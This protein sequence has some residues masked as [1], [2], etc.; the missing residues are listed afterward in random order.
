M[1]D[2]SSTR[3]GSSGRRPTSSSLVERLRRRPFS[4]TPSATLSEKKT[5]FQPTSDS[6]VERVRLAAQRA[7]LQI[8]PPVV[9][10]EEI[11]KRFGETTPASVAAPREFNKG[12]IA[13]SRSPELERIKALPRRAASVTES[14]IADLHEELCLPGGTRRLR[15]IQALALAEAR[16]TGGLFAPIGVGAGKSDIALLLPT[17]MQSKKAVLF[18]PANLRKKVFEQ[19]YPT[20]VDQY[21]VPRLMSSKIEPLGA[22]TLLW[23][24]SYNELSSPTKFD[25]LEK[26]E[27]DLVICD[28]AHAL[29]Y[30]SATRTKRFL[31]YFKTHRSTRLCVL[32][33][34]MTSKSI[35]DYAHL[36]WLSL[37]ENVPLPTKW[38]ALEEWAAALDSSFQPAPPGALLELCNEGESAREGFRRRVIETPGVV[39]TTDNTIGTSLVFFERSLKAPDNVVAA[40][41][42]MRETWT[43]PDQGEAFDDILTLHRFARQ[44]AAGF[45]YRWIWPNG[46][47]LTVRNSW[48]NARKAWN[49]EVAN[50]LTY[51]AKPGI[52]SPLLLAKACA[53]G[54][55][56][57]MNYERWAAVKGTA[58][59]AVEAVWLSDYLVQ[60]AVS[61]GHE[62]VGIIWYEHAAL[63]AAIARAGG[64]P[65]FGPGGDG[66]LK[67]RGTRTIVASIKAHGTGKNLQKYARNL[68][69]TAP[70]SGTI[71]EQLLGR[72][73]RPG[74]AADEVTVDLY[75]HTLE[76]RAALTKALR[77]AQY[78]QTT[79]G[80]QQK[81]LSATYTFLEDR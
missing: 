9:L 36:A 4:P 72:T 77:D 58:Q 27:P 15:P 29:R 71:W 74:Q 52:D 79:T 14:E 7:G 20:L 50:Y 49:Q 64:F 21:R 34:T 35:K 26:I 8:P 76:M 60:D 56:H 10:P 19:D 57:S 43:T 3:T 38:S 80:N 30:P 47:P 5:E 22:S 40:L 45:Y 37:R 81:L 33:G 53:D 24:Y 67:E 44:L 41:K 61:W 54:R 78:Q 18:V 32:S 11:T 1:A 70:T 66:I 55:V 59:P 51:R 73:H 42:T 65:L 17:V 13:V 68:V 48:I 75:R 31:Q 28:E 39:A 69:T 12:G 46:E 6:L 16:R 63:G 2:E 25:L 23:V 62:G